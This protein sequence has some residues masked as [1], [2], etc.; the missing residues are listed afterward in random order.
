MLFTINSPIFAK[1]GYLYFLQISY[2]FTDSI[3]FT[4]LVSFWIP[5]LPYAS[6]SYPLYSAYW[7]P[8]LLA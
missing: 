7:G 3:F 6:S 2:P 4:N 1:V 8:Y 5:L